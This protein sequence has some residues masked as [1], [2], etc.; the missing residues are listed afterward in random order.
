[1][2]NA[3]DGSPTGSEDYPAFYLDQPQAVWDFTPRDPTE[4]VEP[5]GYHTDTAPGEAPS[6]DFVRGYERAVLQERGMRGAEAPVYDPQERFERDMREAELR[7]LDMSV[8]PDRPEADFQQD[9]RLALDA[10]LADVTRPSAPEAPLPT[11]L[12][13][14]PPSAY[15]AS[16]FSPGADYEEDLRR[17]LDLSAAEAANEQR[18]TATEP[19]W[20]GA[21]NWTFAGLTPSAQAPESPVVSSPVDPAPAF[22]GITR[23]PLPEADPFALQVA[24][25][26]ADAGFPGPQGGPDAQ[27]FASARRPPT[28]PNP[29][30]QVPS[31]PVV[32]S[33][34]N[35]FPQPDPRVPPE[36]D[37]P[38]ADRRQTDRRQVERPWEPGG[39]QQGRGGR[40][41]GRR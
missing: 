13:V 41:Q 12:G 38:D 36:A 2:T 33:A 27:A 4:A 26:R 31:N 6:E 30:F 29:S 39:Q 15:N 1:M 3:P 40:P 34:N 10:S 5:P 21:S 20:L 9:L 25:E 37:H 24:E 23:G 7:S 32:G 17:A 19:A 16:A 8:Q 18:P 14:S 35:Y 11:T 28:A 22:F